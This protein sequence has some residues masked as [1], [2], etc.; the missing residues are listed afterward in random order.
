MHV[1]LTTAEAVEL[2]DRIAKLREV[3][4]PSLGTAILNKYWSWSASGG[5]PE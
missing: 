1:P 4:H 3:L 2:R 5:D